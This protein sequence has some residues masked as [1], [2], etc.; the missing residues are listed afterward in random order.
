MNI[1][2][3]NPITHPGWDQLILSHEGYSFFH[4]SA[5][6]SVLSEPYGYKPLYFTI[7]DGD[8]ISACLPVMEVNSLITGRRGVSLPFTDRCEPLVSDPVQFDAL[9]AYAKE[10][11]KKAGWKY[12]ELR[13]GTTFL[14]GVGPSVSYLGHRLDLASGEVALFSAL[15]DSTRRNIKKAEKEGVEVTVSD[16][17]DAVAAFYELNQITR[18]HHGLP[19]QPFS[20]F[21]AIHGHVLSKGLGFVVLALYRGKPVAASVFFHFGRTA[22]YKYGASTLKHQQVRANN[23]AMWKAIERLSRRGLESLCFGRTDIDHGGLRQ[24]KA[25]WGAQEY[26]INYYRHDLRQ[27]KFVAQQHPLNGFSKMIFGKLPVPVL[28]VIG[29]LAYRHMG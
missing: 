5:W 2:I 24:F 7:F 16:T 19:S 25:G 18:K 11:G 23:L 6:A 20:F 21:R 10:H 14:P 3:V 15:R 27:D 17:A 12:I 28:N 29:S 4:S 1:E 8:T 22:L 9:L 26:P 13:G